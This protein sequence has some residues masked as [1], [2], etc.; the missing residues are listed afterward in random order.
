VD[1]P[2]DG[3]L[4][5]PVDPASPPRDLARAAAFAVAV[6]LMSLLLGAVA[7]RNAAEPRRGAPLVSPDTFLTVW[8]LSLPLA[9]LLLAGYVAVGRRRLGRYERRAGFLP[10]AGRKALPATGRKTLFRLEYGSRA[11]HVCLIVVRW[12]YGAST[13]WRRG[14]VVESVWRQADDA[15]G[16]GE[17]RARLTALAERLEEQFDDARFDGER[18]RVLAEEAWAERRELEAQSHLLAEELARDSR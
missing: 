17:Q 3:R 11:D 7:A 15:V 8:L 5:D 18:E 1:S 4:P 12:D 16:I 10:R 13:G 14:R 6:G 9:A 2:A